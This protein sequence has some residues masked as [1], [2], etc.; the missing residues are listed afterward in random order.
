ML[1]IES[2]MPQKNDMRSHS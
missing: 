2:L 1:F